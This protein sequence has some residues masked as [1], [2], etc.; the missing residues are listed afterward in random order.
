MTQQIGGLARRSVLLAPL[1]LS[2]CGLW[3]N[4]FGDKKTPL[5]GKREP[6]LAEP[7]GLQL[8]SNAP[9]VVLPA[10]VRNAAWPQTGGNPAHLMG[11][12][13]A[14]P[15]LTEAW[16]ADIGEGGGYRQKLLA[17]PVVAGD[18]V[19]TMAS[20]GM[21]SAFQLSNGARVWRTDSKAKHNRSTNIGGGLAYDQGVLYA[22]NGVGE[23]VAFDP[24]NGKVRW[25]TSF[26][27][28]ARSA[29]TVAEGRIFFVTIEDRLVVL[30]TQDGRRLWEHLATNPVTQ[31][32]GQPAPA[33]AN[34]L[35]VAAFG[36]GEIACLRADSGN[37]VWSDSL[38]GVAASATLADFSSIRGRPVISNGK[39][40]AIGMGGL[41]LGMDLPTGRRLWEREV[42]GENSPWIAGSWMFIISLEQEIAAIDTATGAV[43]WVSAL[44]RWNNEKK[45]SGLIS[46]WG[47]VLLSDR[48]VVTGTTGEALAVSPYNGAILGR[49]RLSSPASPLEP[50][51]A[52]GTLLVLTDAGR[53]LALR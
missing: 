17:Q 4:W 49:Q 39:V 18:L 25:R 53:L 15:N 27:G 43:A 52:Q 46:W 30:A 10:P 32:L 7:N 21:V 28:P 31:L 11:H 19:F 44:P 47:P 14:R 29:P 45:H 13:E 24:A 41:A 20:N 26:G 51:I 50:V 2:G 33:Y 23:A 6:I 8:A 36:S 37:L 3:Q 1:A 5:P 22:V 12:L 35:L 48:L 9:K 42:A 34:G 40:F 38:G 16:R